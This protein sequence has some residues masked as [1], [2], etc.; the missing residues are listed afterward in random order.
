MV[1]GIYAE[2][3]ETYLDNELREVV[4]LMALAMDMMRK[5]RRV[6][7]M[8]LLGDSYVGLQ[9]D[10]L[11]DT[12]S[13]AGSEDSMSD[14]DDADAGFAAHDSN[15]MPDDHDAR[16]FHAGT[17]D[18]DKYVNPDEGVIV[19]RGKQ[20]ACFMSLRAC[21]E[22][23]SSLCQHRARYKPGED[24]RQT[25]FQMAVRNAIKTSGAVVNLARLL[26]LNSR[27]NELMFWGLNALFFCLRDGSRVDH[28]N[29]RA[30]RKEGKGNRLTEKLRRSCRKDPLMKVH[31]KCI[32]NLLDK[33]DTAEAAARDQQE[34]SV[35]LAVAASRVREVGGT[36]FGGRY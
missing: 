18:E 34:E 14:H 28:D 2:K 4:A 36:G 26:R 10:S 31:L 33:R 1:E 11:M 12:D 32:K 17:N 27:D 25:A 13:D 16:A 20:R 23:L 19:D 6:E 35:P 8:K 3:I 15:S 30:L 5:A 24:L 7:R 22:F 29:V 21:C 9:P